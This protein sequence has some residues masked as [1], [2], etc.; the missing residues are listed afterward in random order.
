MAAPTRLP[1]TMPATCNVLDTHVTY[2]SVLDTQGCV[3]NT[4]GCALENSL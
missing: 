2:C 3:L 1:M 4:H